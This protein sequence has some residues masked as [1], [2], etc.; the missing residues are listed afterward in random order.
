MPENLYFFK[1]EPSKNFYFLQS[2]ARRPDVTYQ[3]GDNF[4]MIQF[5]LI[6]GFCLLRQ[7]VRVQSLIEATFLLCNLTI[8]WLVFLLS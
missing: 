1:D 6:V 8:F 7:E 3:G 2:L 4:T 5:F